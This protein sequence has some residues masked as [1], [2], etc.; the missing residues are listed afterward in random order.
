[1]RTERELCGRLAPNTIERLIVDDG[2][3]TDAWEVVGFDVFA[4]NGTGPDVQA[5][6]SL[7]EKG[8]KAEWDASDNRQIGWGFMF[9]GTNGGAIKSWIR[10][11]V[12]VSD[13]WIQNFGGDPLNY[14]VRV[15]RRDITDDQAILALIQERSQDDL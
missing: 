4:T 11:H 13:L 10:K 9:I 15:R 12:V 3:F 6:L 7:S 14:V 1:M 8:L 2:R 5:V